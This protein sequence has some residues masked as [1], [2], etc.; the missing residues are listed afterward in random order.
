MDVFL[1]VTAGV[2]ITTIVT[3]TISRH[4][5]DISLLLTMFV[6]CMVLLVAVTYLKPVIEFMQKLVNVG[7]IDNEVFN[8]LLKSTGIGLISQIA[9]TICSDSGNQSLGKALQYIS[10]TTILY[11]SLPLLDRLLQLI[12]KVLGSI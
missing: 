11:L 4:S 2:L 9:C 10:S 7:G 6:C 12:E 1:K 5:S 8:I 3:I